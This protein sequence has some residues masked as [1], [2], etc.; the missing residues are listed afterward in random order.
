VLVF[1]LDFLALYFAIG[2][3]FDI[4][5]LTSV[6]ITTV[7][8]GTTPVAFFEGKRGAPQRWIMYAVLCTVFVFGRT[9]LVFGLGFLALYFAIGLFFD[10]VTLTSVL[11]TTVR[12][13]TTPVAFFEGKRM[14]VLLHCAY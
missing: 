8:L 13:G 2:L 6:L 10:T 5:T 12:L 4:V 1:G 3:F 11:I 7:R 9:V 14:L